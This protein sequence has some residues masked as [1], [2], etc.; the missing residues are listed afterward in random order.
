MISVI[1]SLIGFFFSLRGDTNI[2]IL[3]SV[4]TGTMG[5][6]NTMEMARIISAR[7]AIKG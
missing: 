2:R 3:E 6:I 1:D 7:S 5:T 4:V